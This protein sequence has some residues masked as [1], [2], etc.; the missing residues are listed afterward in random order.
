M[1]HELIINAAREIQ[2][3]VII[4]W[5]NQG[6]KVVGYTCSY[7]PKELLYA[8]QILPVRLRGIGTDGMAIADA[9]YGPFICSFPKCMLQLAGEGK[10]SFLDGVIITDGCDS[11]RRLD[12]CWRKA[13]DDY[14]GIKPDF[15]HYFGVPHKKA[16]HGIQWLMEEIL[17]LK[18]RLEDHFSIQI[19]HDDLMQSIRTY[20]K[21]RQLIKQIADIRAQ[22]QSVI[23]GTDAFMITL[24]GTVMPCDI[25]HDH[26]AMF[27]DQLSQHTSEHEHKHRI[28]IVGSADDDITLIQLIENAGAIVAAE[29]VCFSMDL[30][31]TPVNEDTD[32]IR[33]LAERY[34]CNATCPRMFGQ[35]ESR[36]NH[37]KHTIEKNHI[38]GVILQNIRF[39]DL[40]GSENG[41]F[42]KD[43]EAIGIP[44]M[45]IER[46]YGSQMDIGRLQMRIDA[47]LERL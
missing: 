5:K 11:M 16:L 47:F 24:A 44:C 25:Y 31:L 21:G 45:R 7:L 29:K 20:N 39:C 12:E 46:E 10:L 27:I 35:Y 1:I 37:L 33:S 13:S 28:M 34:L 42:E 32:P 30:E 14:S 15:F 22:K 38:Q 40:H 17:E 4:D 18:K 41:L 6:K 3:Q 2:S 8:A 23:T 19:T 26:L 43:L 36:L 9:Y